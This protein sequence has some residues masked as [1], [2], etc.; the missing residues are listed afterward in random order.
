MA[1]VKVEAVLLMGPPI[2]KAVITPMTRP[3]TTAELP[4]RLPSTPVSQSI[5]KPSGVARM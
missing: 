4:C 5:T 1:M 2:S 3:V